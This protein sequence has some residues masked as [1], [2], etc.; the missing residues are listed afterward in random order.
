MV[1]F[2]METITPKKA[3]E[4]LSTNTH[5]R[6]VR[7]RIVRTYSHDM[8]A[9][10]WEWNG[11]SVKFDTEGVLQDGQHRL[12]ACVEAGV[13]F[14][15]LVIRGLPPSVQDTMD[16]NVSRK[17]NDVLKL[18]GEKSYNT[19]AATVRGVAAWEAGGVY[20]RSFSRRFSNRELD[21]VLARYPWLRDG[22]ALI[23]RISRSVALPA[24]AAGPLW[25]AFSMIDN[26]DAEH[27][28]DR[29][30]SD[31]GHK[32]GDPITTLRRALIHNRDNVRGDRNIKYLMALVIKSWNKYRAGDEMFSVSFRRGGAS[33]ESFPEAI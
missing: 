9:G 16:T 11:D 19:L 32:D 29:L 31:E 1:T 33:P 12:L 23:K 8:S 17:Y 13:P 28:F 20:A 27:F 15:T 18:R 26:E 7:P 5:N 30:T 2:E 24:S 10:L 4:Y 21:L 25:W 22:S 14:V 6:D 3:G